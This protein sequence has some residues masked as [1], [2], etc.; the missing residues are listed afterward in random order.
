MTKIICANCGE[1]IKGDYYRAG[2]NST[3]FCSKQCAYD[4]LIYF[5]VDYVK[6]TL[7]PV[8]LKA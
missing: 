7:R 2:N 6:K 1:P 5:G 8:P 4:A 3:T